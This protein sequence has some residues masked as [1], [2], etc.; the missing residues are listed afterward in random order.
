MSTEQVGTVVLGTCIRTDELH[1]AENCRVNHQ[2]K[3]HDAQWKPVA[4]PEVRDELAAT[5][6]RALDVWPK[7]NSWKRG[8][9]NQGDSI[10]VVFA[11]RHGATNEIIGRGDTELEAWASI[12][13]P[14]PEVRADG[15][16]G[17]A[18]CVWRRDRR[19]KARDGG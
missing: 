14:A 7:A 1:S 2:G 11:Q 13:L 5:K 15:A 12:Q 10:W 6:E 3:L 8:G 4:A 18:V 19:P 9:I 16:N 17:V